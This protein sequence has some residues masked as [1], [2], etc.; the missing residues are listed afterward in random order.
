[1][2][3][4][5]YEAATLA[6]SLTRG[7]IEA[8]SERHARQL[9]RERGDTPV[10]IELVEQKSA[11]AGFRRKL[12]ANDLALATRQ[13]ANLIG[14][15][16]PM[17]ASLAALIEQTER[18]EAREVWAAVRS[19]VMAGASLAAGMADFPREFDTV[20]RALIAAG[21]DSGNLGRVLEKLADYLETRGAL[22]AKVVG[23]MTYPAIVTVIALIIVIALMT[24]VV[25]QVVGVFQST[26]QELPLLTRVMVWISG[27]LRQWG[28]LL[29]IVLAAGGFVLA[30][31][32]QQP[33]VKAQW[34]ARLL[35]L[36]IVGPIIRALETERFASTLAILVSGGVP[37]LRALEAAQRTI[38][39]V[40]L[41]AR[42][43]EAIGRVREGAG[44]AKALAAQ[45]EQGAAGKFPPVLIHLIASGE[46]TGE[47][48][49]M[50]QRAADI[51]ARDLER[52]TLTLTALM[53]PALVVGMGGL[54]L[55]IVLAV[56]MPIIEINS[57]VK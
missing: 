53:E 51:Q 4:F 3:A 34:H 41:N 45:S 33:L 50:L 15:R 29:A 42:V 49:V 21:E 32:L 56:L 24:Y 23:A 20:Y 5:R 6:G 14:A 7:V 8:D 39:N 35:T 26:K 19:R 38:N 37:L 57:L 12:S 22:R 40:A 31:V 27:F 18:R 13:L 47:L 25:P 46:R 54:V 2:A 9:L 28:W 17:E 1:M 11:A 36:P 52:R 16:L 55:L 30:R 44:L 10:S 43:A 48:P